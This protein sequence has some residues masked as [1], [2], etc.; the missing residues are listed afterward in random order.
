[1]SLKK[2]LFMPLTKALY[3]W[4]KTARKQLK[5]GSKI[6]QKNTTYQNIIPLHIPG[7]EFKLWKQKQ[8]LKLNTDIQARS[9][10]NNN[11]DNVMY[12]TGM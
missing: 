12:F 9:W 2:P 11:N 1:M 3:L 5:I 10:N 8:L 6:L 4:E 7:Q